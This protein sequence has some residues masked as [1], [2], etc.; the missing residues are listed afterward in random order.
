MFDFDKLRLA[1]N[2]SALLL[3]EVP[4]PL[5]EYN[6]SPFAPTKTMLEPTLSFWSWNL[7]LLFDFE[8]LTVVL[9]AVAETENVVSPTES[10]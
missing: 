7:S 5:T 6:V 10:T 8:D 1:A 4:V 9:L 3:L 2:A